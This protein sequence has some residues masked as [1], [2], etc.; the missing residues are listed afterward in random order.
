MGIRTGVAE[1]NELDARFSARGLGEEAKNKTRTKLNALVLA[2]R[3]EIADYITRGVQLF[4]D[5]ASPD[6]ITAFAWGAAIVAYPYFGKVAEFTGWLT[7]MQGDCS[8]PEVHRRMSELYGDRR[9]VKTAT[10]AVIQSQV[11]WGAIRRIA[12]GNRLERLTP[13]SIYDQKQAA[14]LIEAL[15]R[16]HG[17][18]IAIAGLP[19]HPV[20]FPF[21]FDMSV[22]Y[23]VSE[24]SQL[25][26]QAEGV[27]RQMV[28]L[29]MT[30]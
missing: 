11:D 24:S 9:N 15:L 13:Q 20:L 5:T 10:R 2:P 17:R 16:F 23:V 6:A 22:A 8:M 27:D 12:K 19:S 21:V 14:W 7:A 3:E 29:G 26:I 28:A 25:E 1:A 18:P 4:A 30:R